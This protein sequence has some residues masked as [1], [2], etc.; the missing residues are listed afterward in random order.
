MITGETSTA[1]KK[2]SH[3]QSG[4]K[5]RDALTNQVANLISSKR[6]KTELPLRLECLDLNC[7]QFV[8]HLHRTFT[9]HM[10]EFI[11]VSDASD[12]FNITF[13]E[14]VTPVKSYQHNAKL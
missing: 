4:L 9:I 5:L 1:L 6:L 7:A 11:Y 12:L 3:R 14:C 8:S 2:K 13:K 10:P